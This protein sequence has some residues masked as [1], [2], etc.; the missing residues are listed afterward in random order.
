MRKISLSTNVAGDSEYGFR[1]RAMALLET[2]TPGLFEH[3]KTCRWI[4]EGENELVYVPESE[5]KECDRTPLHRSTSSL[6]DIIHR[7]IIGVIDFW[8]D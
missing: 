5:L 7:R 1:A 8:P 6:T 2:W 3:A 4:V